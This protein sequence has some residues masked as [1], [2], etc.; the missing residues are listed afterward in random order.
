MP[1]KFPISVKSLKIDEFYKDSS[2]PW[3]L[4]GKCGDLVKV[5]PCADEYKNKTYLGIL[6]GDLPVGTFVSFDKK[7]GKMEI[8]PYKNPAIFVPALGK[9]IWGCGSWS[10]TLPIRILITSGM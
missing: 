4:G 8:M 7:T 1:I 2:S 9:I 10:R 3:T 6:L 5:R